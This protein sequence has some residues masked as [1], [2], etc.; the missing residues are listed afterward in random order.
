MK[1]FMDKDFLLSTETAQ[2]L[3]HEHAE[4][5]PIIDYHC[6]I[7]PREIAEDRRFENITEI[8]LG[9]DHYKW[10][11]MRSAGVEE[12]YITGDAPAREKFQ[13]WAE[14][15][16]RAIGNPLYHW[17]HLE[18]QRYF[19]YEGTLN[20]ETAEEVWNLT[21]AKLSEEG[22]SA[23]GI[24]KTSNVDTLCT[25]DDPIDTLEWHEAIEKDESF[26]V[27]VYPAWR[28]DKAMNIEKPD[29]CEYI[30]KLSAI[31]G[32]NCGTFESL[33]KALSLRMDH[34]TAHGCRI[35]DHGLEYMMYEP[36]SEAEI[37][38][39]F[40]ARCRGAELTREQTQKYKTAFMVF[41]AE[42]YY[43][44][45]WIMQLH[46]GC[47]RDNNPSQFEKLGPDTGYDCIN[48][49]AP[50]AQLTGFLGAI[51]ASM[52][53]TIIYSL[54]PTDNAVIGTVIGC[55]QSAPYVAKIQQGSAWWFNDHITGMRDQMISLANLGYLAG[56]VGMLTDSRSFLSYPRHEY[57]RRILCDLLGDWVEK[58]M[59]PADMKTLGSITEDIS[60]NNAKR[61]FNF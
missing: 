7:N 56:F 10:R 38:E 43:K 30:G 15:L 29:F 51:S 1:A 8:W 17:S 23:R 3:F 36:A 50:A 59:Y 52:P 24:I 46:Y 39:I 6:H 13:K 16:S 26:S 28:P 41:C 2:K 34:F 18:L 32:E 42:E 14:T 21:K 35:S 55:F 5:M 57:F 49:Y 60:Y 37:E 22:M 53:K 48:N 12:Y 44:R 61:Y 33:K 4:K 47:L 9:G 31:T 19:G 54:N 25:T 58:G 11:L 20:G 45:E 27:K 40:A